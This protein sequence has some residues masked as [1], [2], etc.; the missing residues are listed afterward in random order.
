[1]LGSAEQRWEL[2]SHYN[3]LEAGHV[4]KSVDV[5][6]TLLPTHGGHVRPPVQSPFWQVF[7]SPQST[8]FDLLPVTQSFVADSQFTCL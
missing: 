2:P 1:V 4:Q 5:L 7:P 8:P 3:G 6:Q